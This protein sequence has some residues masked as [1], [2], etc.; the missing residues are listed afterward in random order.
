MS[1]TELSSPLSTEPRTSQSRRK[2]VAALPPARPEAAPAEAVSE[3]GP[4]PVADSPASRNRQAYGVL[5]RARGRGG[6]YDV[7]V[8]PDALVI[9]RASGSDPVLIGAALGALLASVLGAVVG[10][11]IGDRIARKSAANRLHE[12]FY[13]RPE[14][15]FGSDRRNRFVRAQD[16]RFARFLEFGPR[17]R[18][19]ELRM[20]D[21]RR[22][23]LRFDARFESNSF[24]AEMLRSVLASRLRVE[25]HRVSAMSLFTGAL[26][27]LGVL[28]VS[29]AVLALF[30][31]A[32]S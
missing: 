2:A 25:R 11:V 28:V 8:Y 4:Q 13:A 12:L 22:Y 3:S 16:V 6:I 17:R 15:T 10:V 24:A 1:V 9:A 20:Q 26:T 18:G 23:R 27:V 30:V 14:L 32:T 31:A 7:V 21:G 29:T 19:L 5:L